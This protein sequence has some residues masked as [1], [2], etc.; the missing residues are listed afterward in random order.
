MKDPLIELYDINSSIMPSESA[1]TYI[2]L[3]AKNII[4]EDIEV[5]CVFLLHESSNSYQHIES[6]AIIKDTERH[7]NGTMSL[8]ECA[9]PRN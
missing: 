2:K 3:R 6:L 1:V 8:V 4:L 5:K 9:V 7:S